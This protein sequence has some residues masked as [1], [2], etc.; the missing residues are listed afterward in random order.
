MIIA[1]AFMGY[2]HDHACIESFHSFL[3]KELIYLNKYETREEV[4]L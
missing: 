4:H 3:K 1:V 2:A